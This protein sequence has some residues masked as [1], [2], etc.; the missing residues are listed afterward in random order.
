MADETPSGLNWLAY[1]E[2]QA[3]LEPGQIGRDQ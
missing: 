1:Q 2:L 3:R